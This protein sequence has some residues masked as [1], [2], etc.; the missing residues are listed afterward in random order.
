[1]HTGKKKFVKPREYLST[2]RNK[3]HGKCCLTQ[4]VKWEWMANHLIS[5]SICNNAL[6]KTENIT[7]LWVFLY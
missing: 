5:K 3:K 1:M 2:Q 6:L 7:I 4:Q